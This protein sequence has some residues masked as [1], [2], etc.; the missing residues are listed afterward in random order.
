MDVKNQNWKN[1]TDQHLYDWHGI[2]TRYS[3][4]GEVKESFRSLR[5]FEGNAEKTEI[6]QLNQY[7]FA[8]DDV[9]EQRWN[10][11]QSEHS[12]SDGMFHPQARLMR[13]YFLPSG[14][15][16]WLTTQLQVGGYL[17]M[18]LFFKYQHLRH[19]VGIIYDDQGNL[20]RTANI[21]EDST[22]YPSSYWST[23][24][25]QLS[26]RDLKGNWQGTSMII[27]PDLTIS[28]PVS[29]QLSWGWERHKT[30]FLP[31]GVSISCPAQVTI[32]TPFSCA[33]N[34][35]IND[36]EIHQLI[37]NYDTAGSFTNLTLERCELKQGGE[38]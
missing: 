11:N 13:G 17:A 25:E 23:E 2:W 18:E 30:F 1:F 27:T 33:V 8:E 9:K 26:Q 14:H 3:P 10:Y 32:G 34:W 4:E 12:L 6:Y 31:D 22:G 21:R 38:R 19:S 24:L 35:L 28:K 20:F 37:A 29:T 16:A 36:P 5:H 7:I 15:S